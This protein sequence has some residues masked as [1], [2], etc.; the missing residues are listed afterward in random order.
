VELES[1]P[2]WT[3]DIKSRAKSNNDENEEEVDDVI[4]CPYDGVIKK[5]SETKW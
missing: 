3:D 2:I 1:L 5:G 4:G